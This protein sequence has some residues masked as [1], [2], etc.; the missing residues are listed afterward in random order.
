[1]TATTTQDYVYNYWLELDEPLG[2]MARASRRI[3]QQTSLVSQTKAANLLSKAARAIDDADMVKA[4]GYVDRA[5]RLPFDHHEESH[6]AAWTA[7]V[8]LF[9]LVVDEMEGCSDD[10]GHW[11]DAA[12]EVMT[13]SDETGRFALRDVLTVI[14]KDFTIGDTERADLR[15]ATASVPPC[16]EL[17]DR[18]LTSPQLVDSLLA[19]LAVGNDYAATCTRLAPS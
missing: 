5:V 8:D 11:L 1:M 18:D 16:A 12:I 13:R 17:I 2:P 19:I 4:R 6:P 15:A 3:R 14:D 10:D 9:S 7:S